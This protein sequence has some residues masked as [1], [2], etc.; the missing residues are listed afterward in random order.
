MQCPV[1]SQNSLVQDSTNTITI[2]A[3]THQNCALKCT[4]CG[5]E[6]EFLESVDGDT[7]VWQ[8]L[9]DNL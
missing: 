3:H 4:N 2:G 6:S 7:S 8:R 9:E 1:C 5:W